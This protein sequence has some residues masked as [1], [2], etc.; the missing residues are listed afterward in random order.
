MAYNPVN[1]LHPSLRKIYDEALLNYT[2]AYHGA[3]H[4][5]IA[6]A[7]VSNELQAANY[8][9]GR[10]SQ[11]DINELRNAVGL[12]QISAYE[13][14]QYVTNQPAGK[15]P[16]NL[17]PALA[18]RFV[19]YDHK[20]RVFLT[21]EPYK[22]FQTYLVIAARKFNI[23]IVLNE[24]LAD[25]T[26]YSYIELAHWRTIANPKDK[27]GKTIEAL[28]IAPLDGHFWH[29]TVLRKPATLEEIIKKDRLKDITAEK[30]LAVKGNKARIYKNYRPADKRKYKQATAAHIAPGTK[31]Q[32]PNTALDPENV[33]FD[34]NRFL[35]ETNDAVA[36]TTLALNNLLTEPGYRQ[37]F[38]D[39]AKGVLLK[40]VPQVSVWIWCKTL[41]PVGGQGTT[42]NTVEGQIFN[43]TPF[44]ESLN[45]QVTA[46]GGSFTINLPPLTCEAT[47][48]GW[49]L[50][51]GSIQTF[52]DN[53][54]NLNY[55]GKD[56]VV[57]LENDEYRS[58][59][60]MFHNL[61]SANDVV[62]IRFEPLVNEKD[63]T[64]NQPPSPIINK[65]EL[66]GK[67]YDMIGLI[68]RNS[69]R[70]DYGGANVGINLTGRDLMKLLIEDSSTWMTIPNLRPIE[71]V[72]SNS[73][74]KKFGRAVRRFE[75][76]GPDNNPLTFFPQYR[77]QNIGEVVELVFSSLA[78][79]EIA[80]DSLFDA[81]PRERDL[82][83]GQEG[84]SIYNQYDGKKVTRV[85]GAGI[86]QII[87]V[88][89]DKSIKDRVLA[90]D[91]I[92]THEGSLLNGIQKYVQKPFV[93]MYSD[94]YNDQ[95]YFVLRKPPTDYAGYMSL[96]NMAKEVPAL[97]VYA[98]QVI[99]ESL[100]FDDGEVYC[101]YR[102]QGKGAL[103]GSTQDL[104]SLN[105]WPIVYL[106]EYNEIWGNR[107]MD[108]ISNYIHGGNVFGKKTRL[109][110][111]TKTRQEQ[112]Y[113]DMR[114]MV[115]SNAYAPFTRKGSITLHGDR[116]FKRGT[117]IYYHLTDE[118]YYVDA[119][120]NNSSINEGGIERTTTLTI[121]RGMRNKMP[122][123][124]SVL[125]MY[126]NIVDFK[127]LNTASNGRPNFDW[128][129]NPTI[130]N[131]FLRRR[132]FSD[133]VIIQPN[134]IGAK[135]GTI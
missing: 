118:Y 37:L 61:I 3:Y 21:V 29:T 1:E 56:S 77:L 57:R 10:R 85:P 6:S 15:S 31:L 106:R 39:S 114:Y 66:P 40:T 135:N 128:E 120:S 133:D 27:T 75:R 94:T 5:E 84:I 28:T 24:V 130:F 126:F 33:Y 20:A 124:Q 96:V 111:D 101:W 35:V 47:S 122:D 12:P 86:W 117:V 67:N 115:E 58:N 73:N 132:Q 46:T 88:L 81:Y 102:L 59:N 22:L 92:S 2:N 48:T 25:R 52:K 23:D 98:E 78:T 16:Q 43:V 127:K 95:F 110:A 41:G 64:T 54:G 125:E 55:V 134:V 93:E 62:F 76:L 119:V 99:N 19:V 109:D 7:H 50:R 17:T 44:V 51:P 72:F 49:R 45:T 34:G 38:R 26:D 91:S 97:H 53:Q 89:M 42:P 108:I 116:R 65:S 129:V 9:Q 112:L 100:N 32:L 83:T 14:K 68:D 90:D 82:A 60:Y 113:N 123:G 131:F 103:G 4:V 87:K 121:S 18:F 105:S 107:S 11:N 8:A 79:I 36:F 30:I 13:V 104:D 74:W 69:I 80:P 63:R 71:G 70:S